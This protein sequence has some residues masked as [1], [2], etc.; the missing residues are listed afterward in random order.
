MYGTQAEVWRGTLNPSK[1][2][3][4]DSTR[5]SGTLH[6]QIFSSLFG[7]ILDANTVYDKLMRSAQR[8][9]QKIGKQVIQD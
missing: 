7:K 2:D 5:S 3:S 4:D 6:I 8:K 9:E 1:P